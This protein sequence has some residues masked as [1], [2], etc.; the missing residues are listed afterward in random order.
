MGFHSSQGVYSAFRKTVALSLNDFRVT[1]ATGDVGDTTANGGVL[2]SNTAPVLS[3]TASTVSQQISWATGSVPQILTQISLP[4]DFDGRDNVLIDLWVNSGTTDAA[5]FTVLTN[6]NGAAAD[7]S[8][9]ADD[10][11]TKSAT[12]HKITAV[13]SAADIPD[14]ASFVSIALTPAA[15]ATNAIQLV[16]ARLTYVPLATS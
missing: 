5:T 12:T 6:W 9:T 10:A 15:H 4:E 13:V 2:S 7:V 14:S 1:T 16:A 8:D 3:G 11:A